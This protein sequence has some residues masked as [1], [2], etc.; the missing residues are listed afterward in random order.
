MILTKED[1][2]IISKYIRTICGIELGIEKM[3]L[4]Q[5][6]LEG[7][8]ESNKCRSFAEFAKIISNNPD[9]YLRDQII[10]MIT[11]NETSFFRDASPFEMFKNLL[12]PKL[13]STIRERNSRMFTR[14]GAKISILS[15]GSSTGQEPYSL[16]MAIHEYLQF[17]ANGVAADDFSIVATDISSRVLAKAISGEYTDN[18]LGRGVTDLQK[19]LFFKKIEGL[20]NV[21]DNIRS[22]IDFRQINFTQTFTHLGGF[23]IIFCRNVMIYFDLEMKTKM[24]QQFYDMM[25][26]DGILILGSTENLYNINVPF[27]SNHFNKAV[28]YTKKK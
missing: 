17:G 21:N 22:I 24:I 1:F 3:Y 20:W 8:A 9:S 27:E 5:Q 25:P 19:Q 6:R 11:T 23:D 26:D 4:V 18:E 13:C 28:Y 7:L 14:K 10:A 12:L 2:E 16:S 15:A